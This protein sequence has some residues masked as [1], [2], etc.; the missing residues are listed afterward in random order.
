M[1]SSG[2]KVKPNTRRNARRPS[3]LW[4]QEGKHEG[5]HLGAGNRQ[6]VPASKHHNVS[7]AVVLQEH[8]QRGRGESPVVMGN[9]V[10]ACGERDGED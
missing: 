7:E 6:L 1:I 9:V 10:P 8:T 2:A 4:E 3:S 5:Y